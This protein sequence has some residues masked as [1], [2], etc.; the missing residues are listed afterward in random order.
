[1]KK[2]TKKMLQSPVNLAIQLHYCN[3]SLSWATVY[4]S[5]TEWK[6]V[7]QEISL[8]NIYDYIYDGMI[9]RAKGYDVD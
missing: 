1:M 7:T 3:L 4:I 9:A 5:N 8:E 2:S 6:E